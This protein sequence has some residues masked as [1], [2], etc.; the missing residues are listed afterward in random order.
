M[1]EVLIPEEGAKLNS[2]KNLTLSRYV[3]FKQGHL[4]PLS[5]I[6]QLVHLKCYKSKFLQRKWLI[7]TLKPIFELSA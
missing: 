5:P 2:G 4:V 1:S 3:T 6:R 7:F